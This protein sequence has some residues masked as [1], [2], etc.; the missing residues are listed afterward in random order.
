LEVTPPWVDLKVGTDPS[1]AEPLDNILT[2]A[3]AWPALEESVNLNP[4]NQR[5][6]LHISATGD[7]LE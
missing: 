4:T 1:A 3:V 7:T 6:D 5:T 2:A